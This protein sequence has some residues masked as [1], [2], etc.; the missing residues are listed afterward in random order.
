MNEDILSYISASN[1]EPPLST[2][3]PLDQVSVR[4]RD[5]SD[6][7]DPDLLPSRRVFAPATSSPLSE[8]LVDPGSPTDFR[9]RFKRNQPSESSKAC[10]QSFDDG[11][12]RGM[13]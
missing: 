5:N 7:G 1:S 9:E 6:S 12:A 3:G 10:A 13:E 11:A 4:R 8:L 2:P